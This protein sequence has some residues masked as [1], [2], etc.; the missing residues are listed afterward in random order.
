MKN[1]DVFFSCEGSANVCLSV[2]PSVCGQFEIIRFK[3][4]PEGPGMFQNVP[5]CS[6]RFKK[7]IL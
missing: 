6:I 4:F 2:R 1:S 7:D 3:K 5:E